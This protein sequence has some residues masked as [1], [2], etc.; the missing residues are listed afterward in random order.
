MGMGVRL[1]GECLRA[2]KCGEHMRGCIAEVVA[3]SGNSLCARV[4]ARVSVCVRARACVRVCS[5]VCVCV[6]ACARVCVRMCFL[7]LCASRETQHLVSFC[8]CVGFVSLG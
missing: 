1:G 5:C 8:P 4:H 6:C 2:E 7:G 3:R